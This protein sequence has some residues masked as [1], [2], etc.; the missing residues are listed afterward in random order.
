MEE[1]NKIESKIC[2]L[3]LLELKNEY[4]VMLQDSLSQVKIKLYH[5]WA[6]GRNEFDSSK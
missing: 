1:E 5:D 3:F 2:F 4:A 6:L